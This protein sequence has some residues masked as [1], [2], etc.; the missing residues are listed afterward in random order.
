MHASSALVIVCGFIVGI[1]CRAT[2]LEKTTAVIAINC[3]N[4]PRCLSKFAIHNDTKDVAE[5]AKTI[6][7]MFA[8]HG[9]SKD[10][11][12]HMMQVWQHFMH[13]RVDNLN[14]D[15]KLFVDFLMAIT[16]DMHIVCVDPA[17]LLEARSSTYNLN[18]AIAT[19]GM[20]IVV[21]VTLFI[22]TLQRSLLIESH[23]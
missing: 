7:L 3:V 18:L 23:K 12:Y 6:E 11:G 5:L 19:I 2:E 4:E 14:G 8:S 17:E 15:D 1:C 20:V 16:M 10:T 9:I 22:A 21:F 13:A